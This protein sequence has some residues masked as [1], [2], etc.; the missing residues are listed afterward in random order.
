DQGY[1]GRRAIIIPVVEEILD[2][3]NGD[4]NGGRTVPMPMME[5]MIEPMFLEGVVEGD[6]DTAEEVQAIE[7]E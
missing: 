1:Y 7:V 3:H 4:S 6:G 2:Q 5:P